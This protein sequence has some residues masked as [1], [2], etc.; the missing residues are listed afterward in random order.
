MRQ[1]RGLLAC[2]TDDCEADRHVGRMSALGLIAHSTIDGA[3]IAAVALI[4]WRAGVVV[5]VGIIVHDITWTEHNSV[6][7]TWLTGKE[8]FRFLG[9]RRN[10]T[11]P[12][13]NACR[14]LRHVVA[15]PCAPSRSDSWILP[16]HGN[17]RPVAGRSSPFAWIRGLGSGS[18]RYPPDWHCCATS[19]NLAVLRFDTGFSSCSKV[20][21]IIESTAAS[22]TRVIYVSRL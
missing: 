17:R 7:D 1:T 5:A 11:D 2:P 16:L 12:G 15:S 22:R 20:G 13:R 4:S 18:R 21:P 8:G 9:C 19:I 3:S 6:G 14:C 10:C